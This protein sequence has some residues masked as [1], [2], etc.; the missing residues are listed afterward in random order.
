MSLFQKT[1]LRRTAEM[2][3][4]RALTRRRWSKEQ[5]EA[6]AAYY[7]QML[8]TPA[9]TMTLRPIQGVAIHEMLTVGGLLGIIPVGEGKT[10][11]SLLAPLLFRAMRPVLLLPANLID[12]TRLD[13]GHLMNHWQIPRNIYIQSYE[14][15]GREGAAK[16]LD[17][18]A[19][20]LIVTDE[21]HRLKNCQ[22]GVTRRVKRY[23]TQH[24]QTRF[25]AFSG[26]LYKEDLEDFGHLALW[27]LK[28]GAPVPLNPGELKEWSECLAHNTNP[29]TQ[30]L[31]GPLVTP[32]G[33]LTDQA[34]VDVDETVTARKVF[35]RRLLETPGVVASTGE[36]QV[37]ASLYIKAIPYQVNAVTEANFG[38]LR[39]DMVT[40][41]GWAL[42]DAV[43][44][45]KCA[46]E[47]ALGFHYVWDPRPP[48][49]WME[50]RRLWAQLVRDVLSHSRTLDTEKTV[51]NAV[52]AGDVKPV[53]REGIPGLFLWQAWERMRPTFQV[54]TKP[55]WHDDSALN[56]C[57][58]WAKSGPGIIWTEHA[59]FARELAKRTGLPYFGEEGLDQTGRSLSKFGDDV[60]AGLAKPTSLVASIAANQAGRNLQGWARNLVTSWQGSPNTCEQMLGRTHRPGQK[61]DTVTVDFLLGCREHWDSF[62]KSIIAARAGAQVMGQKQ[63][64]LIGD[65]LVPSEQQIKEWAK[66]SQ[67]WDRNASG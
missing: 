14:T 5:M 65:R 1:T 18:Y 67:R 63:K 23:M 57:A 55:I 26:T 56:L 10:L 33:L 19:P 32:A 34:D 4:V 43:Q 62:D 24:P 40:P 60:N 48:L 6:C 8:K 46:R 17:Q 53:S 27:A 16:W 13:M 47:L 30:V 42:A 2:D 44:V 31:P 64:L 12:K 36:Q 22:A 9:G 54:N 52:I 58:T 25:L 21:S 41:D 15:L 66:T 37:G 51:R 50:A 29:M 20:D 35:Q 39:N 59:F 28:N 49:E 7:T 11:P 45:W 3:R 61:A 38:P